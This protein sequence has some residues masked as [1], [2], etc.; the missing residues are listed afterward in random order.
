MSLPPIRLRDD[1]AFSELAESYR[2]TGIVQAAGF[3]QA[4]S[5]EAIGNLLPRLPYVIV[6]PD[7]AGQTLVIS[8][9]VVRHFG[10]ARVR[11][12]LGDTIKRAANGFAFVHRSYALQDEYARAG[13]QPIA[14]VTEFLQSRPFLEAA[15]RIVGET[16]DSVRVQASHYRPGDFLTLH[17]DSHSQDDR[18]AAFTLGFTRGW[19]PDWGGQLLFH[20][21]DGDVV[22]G[23][24]PR[25]NV[26]T[27]FRVPQAHS[28]APVAPYASQPRLSL[29]GW[30][31]RSGER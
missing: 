21:S 31:I 10:E 19:R 25:F 4:A 11:E 5:A 1:L 24:V 12:F 18:I 29:T 14:Q 20:D 22:R 7:A 8:D 3:L 27:V 13:D 16:V 26:L 30:F 2:T 28:V 15:S 17:V 6:A 9:E 23:L